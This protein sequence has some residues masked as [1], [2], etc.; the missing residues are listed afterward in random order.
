MLVADDGGVRRVDTKVLIGAFN[1]PFTNETLRGQQ[2]NLHLKCLALT[3]RR[4]ILQTFEVVRSVINVYL[5]L[6]AEGEKK[7]RVV[8]VSKGT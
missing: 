3:T 7:Q 8:K 2:G 4:K 1:V 5:H 6:A